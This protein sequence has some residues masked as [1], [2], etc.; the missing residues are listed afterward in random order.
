MPVPYAAA[1]RPQAWAAG[2]ILHVVRAM[3]GLEPDVPNGHLSLRPRLPLGQ[4]ITVEGLRLGA[5]R[6]SFTVAGSDVTDVDGDGLDVIV[7]DD[8]FL[9]ASAWGR[10]PQAAVRG[11]KDH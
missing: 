6:V 7:G 10:S 1:C 11:G 5:H 8:T 2:S 9:A 4:S 3:I